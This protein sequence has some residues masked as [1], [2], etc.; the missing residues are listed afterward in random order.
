MKSYIETRFLALKILTS[1]LEEEKT[2]SEAFFVLDSSL[3]SPSDVAFVRLLVLETLRH[4]GEALFLLDR[5]IEKPIQR[6]NRMIKLILVLAIVQLKWLHVSPHA[7]L[8]TAV[9]LTREI[10]KKPFSGFVNAVLRRFTKLEN[11]HTELTLNLPD[12]LKQ[13]WLEQFG[14]FHFQKIVEALYEAP[15]LDLTVKE[16]PHHW[17]EVLGGEVLP[18]GTVRL[19]ST[20]NVT[21]MPGF[22]AGAWWVQEASASIPALLFSCVQG[23]KGADLC[24]A[25][26]GKT[27]QL[28]LR[29]AF[30]DAF[31]ISEKRVGRLKENMKR[32]GFEKQVSVVVKN[33]LDLEENEVYDFILLDAPCSATGTIKKHPEILHLR[34]FDDV[35]RHAALQK[36]LLKKAVRLLK[37]GGELVYSTCSLEERENMGVVRYGVEKLG[38]VVQKIE[39]EALQNFVSPDQVIQITPD[40]HQDGFFACLFKKV[41]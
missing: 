28:A 17:A 18:H 20:Q 30:V 38:L 22:D 11:T 26:G 13:S 33:V 29:G 36:E 31:D 34:S 9:S 2:T 27:A 24:A 4:F 16:N 1:V 19:S 25:P 12:W 41:I 6:K 15:T 32:L 3:L 37:K 21:L 14:E 7:V 10:G 8:D 39:N 40:M 5:L 23:K 35:D